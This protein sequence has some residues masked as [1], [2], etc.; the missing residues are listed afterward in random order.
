MKKRL[1]AAAV[2]ALGCAMAQAQGK[3]IKIAIDAASAEFLVD[4][5]Y[6][7]EG[8]VKKSSVRWKNDGPWFDRADELYAGSFSGCKVL[9]PSNQ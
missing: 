6:K 8:T 1:L 3:D 7:V 2:A 5:K 4:G 9:A